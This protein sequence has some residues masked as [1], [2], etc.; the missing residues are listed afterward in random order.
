MESNARDGVKY[1]LKLPNRFQDNIAAIYNWQH[2]LVGNE[3]G[4][5]WI[6]GFSLEE[7]NKVEVKSIPSIQ[8]FYS[9]KG[10]LFPL[11]HALPVRNEPALLWTPIQRAIPIDLPKKNHNYFG[12]ESKIKIAVTKSNAEQPAS[13]LR[14]KTIDL[15]KHLETISS[16]RLRPLQWTLMGEDAFVFG[17]PMLPLP[18]VTYW[19]KAEFIIPAGYELSPPLIT[20]IINNKINRNRE[21]YILWT[22]DGSYQLIPKTGL[23]QL[24]RSSFRATFSK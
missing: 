1:F 19:M 7:I 23:N 13:V 18:G 4:V 11:G 5:I 3:G 17:N 6:H 12:L 24:S 15:Q 10:K 22:L 2:L 16:L 14:I 8:R 9:Q 21:N 20:K